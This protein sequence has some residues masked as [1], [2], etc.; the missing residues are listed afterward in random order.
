MKSVLD[1]KEPRDRFPHPAKHLMAR[2]TI[3]RKLVLLTILFLIPLCGA[4]VAVL[5]QSVQSIRATQDEQRGLTLVGRALDFMR[6]TQVRR[7][8]ANGLLLGN[9]TF[10]PTFDAANGKA[11]GH[12]SALRAEV[13]RVTSFNV[14]QDAAKLDERLGAIRKLGLETPAAPL[15]ERHTAGQADAAVCWRCGG[16][17]AA[18]ARPGRRLLLPDQPDGRPDAEAGRA[19]ARWRVAEARASSRRAAIPMQPSRPIS[20]RW[21]SRSRTAWKPCGATSPVPSAVRRP[22]EEPHGS[23]HRQAGRDG[24]LLPAAQG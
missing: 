21:P 1:I 22:S 3:T 14:T 2:L 24:Q 13:A 12:L 7:G 19:T 5:N 23:R 18:G 16:P 9:A 17:L 15:F 8:A 20:P 6:E 4:L 10:R 11:D